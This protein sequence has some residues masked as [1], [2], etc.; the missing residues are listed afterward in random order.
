M[1]NTY[2]LPESHWKVTFL[3]KADADIS[4]HESVCRLLD[5][6]TVNISNAFCITDIPI[7]KITNVPS[8]KNPLKVA[9][10]NAIILDVSP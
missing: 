6:L 4:Y 9:G 8:F 3:D 10:E 2:V 1:T 7:G 5:L